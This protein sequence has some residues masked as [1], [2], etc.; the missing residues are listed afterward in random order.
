[1]KALSRDVA[2][3]FDAKLYSFI[4]ILSTSPSGQPFNIPVY[5]L[6][7]WPLTHSPPSFP[8]PHFDKSPQSSYAS[9]QPRPK[10]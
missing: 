3:D 4:P 2:E 6:L 8:S 9:Q 1:M 5:V 10:S 7:M